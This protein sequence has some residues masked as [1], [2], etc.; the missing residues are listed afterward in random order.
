MSAVN[1]GLSAQA[2]LFGDPT[3]RSSCHY[4]ASFT[5]T[6]MEGWGAALNVFETMEPFLHI[7]LKLQLHF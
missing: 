1:I 7:T 6:C 3:H 2:D 4:R 5:Q